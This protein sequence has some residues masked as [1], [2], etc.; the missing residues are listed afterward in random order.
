MQSIFVNTN[1]FNFSDPQPGWL[2]HVFLSLVETSHLLAESA[3]L[4]SFETETVTKQYFGSEKTFPVLRKYGTDIELLFTLRTEWADNRELF[5]LAHINARYLRSK[6]E[7]YQQAQNK[8]ILY[9]IHPEIEPYQKKGGDTWRYT[10]LEKIVIRLKDKT[11]FT[12]KSYT[13]GK[14][15]NDDD[16]ENQGLVEFTS[17]YTFENCV[18]KSMNFEGALDY[19]SEDILKCKLVYHSDIWEYK[20]YDVVTPINK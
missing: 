15:V 17:E 1:V 6:N 13:D 20:P 12:K 16:K 14:K 9:P 10:D 8:S 18:L 19:N 11:G 5:R 4:P 3:T 2:F 7:N